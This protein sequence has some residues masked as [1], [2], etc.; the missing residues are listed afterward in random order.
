MKHIPGM[1]WRFKWP[2]GNLHRK[3]VCFCSGS[4]ERE[5]REMREN[6]I[7]FTPVLL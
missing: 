6:G 2:R 7:F 1:A 4:V 3:F 5:M